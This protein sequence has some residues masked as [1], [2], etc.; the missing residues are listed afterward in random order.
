[1]RTLSHTAPSTRKAAACLGAQ[2]EERGGFHSEHG[3]LGFL[4][5]CPP[6]SPPACVCQS[7]RGSPCSTEGTGSGPL[8]LADPVLHTHARLASRT[9]NLWADSAAPLVSGSG[10]HA[11]HLLSPVSCSLCLSQVLLLF[12]L[13]VSFLFGAFRL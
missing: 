7:R 3:D 4:P 8:P 5:F 11:L 13:L 9:L 6:G 2:R 12:P 1:M 10:I